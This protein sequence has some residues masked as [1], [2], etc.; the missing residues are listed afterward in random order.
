M[1]NSIEEKI[2]DYNG[3][4]YNRRLRKWRKNKMGFIYENNKVGKDIK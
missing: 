4:I 3:K 1:V 2:K